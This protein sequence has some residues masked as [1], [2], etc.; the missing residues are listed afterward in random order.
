MLGIALSLRPCWQRSEAPDVA[1]GTPAASF[2]F[3]SKD[4]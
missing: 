2:S 3:S 1:V 4:S